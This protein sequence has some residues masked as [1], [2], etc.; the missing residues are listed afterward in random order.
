M[1]AAASIRKIH[2]GFIAMFLV[3]FILS[4]GF[5]NAG[6]KQAT[7][8]VMDSERHLVGMPLY[9]SRS[10]PRVLVPEYEV[11]GIENRKKP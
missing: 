4:Q 2:A 11:E 1:A 5:A 8:N 6:Q 7:F 10:D 9:R 3:T